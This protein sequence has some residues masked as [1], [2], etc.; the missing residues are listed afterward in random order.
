M[1]TMH[2]RCF[3]DCRRQMTGTQPQKG[4]NPS[5]SHDEPADV[6]QPSLGDREASFLVRAIL[7]IRRASIACSNPRRAE[8]TDAFGIRLFPALEAEV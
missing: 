4:R 5:N 6:R 3:L 7:Q 1:A 8:A 2:L